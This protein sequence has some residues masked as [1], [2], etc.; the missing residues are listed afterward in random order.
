MGGGVPTMEGVRRWQRLGDR[1]TF[2]KSHPMLLVVLVVL[3]WALYRH[4]PWKQSSHHG[5][6]KHSVM[7]YELTVSPWPLDLLLS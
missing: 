4:P 3:L 2:R 5:G 6:C 1:L 7:L